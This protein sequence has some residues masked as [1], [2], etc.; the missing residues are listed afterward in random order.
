MNKLLILLSLFSVTA[1]AKPKLPKFQKHSLVCA[2]NM[3]DN[4]WQALAFDYGEKAYPALD[5]LLVRQEGG[6]F[7]YTL[8][9]SGDSVL[10]M[11]NITLGE[12]DLVRAKDRDNATCEYPTK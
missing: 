9:P 3:P 7:L 6:Q 11:I 8:S 12:G 10:F 1:Q 5:V 2:K 4:V